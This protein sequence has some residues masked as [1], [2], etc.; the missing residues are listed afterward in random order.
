MKVVVV[1]VLDEDG[2]RSGTH[3]YLGVTEKKAVSLARNEEVKTLMGGMDRQHARAIVRDTMD[4]HV[5]TVDI[6]AVLASGKSREQDGTPAP[7]QVVERVSFRVNRLI[8]HIFKPMMNDKGRCSLCGCSRGHVYH[9]RSPL[10]L[11]T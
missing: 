7:Q 3:A 11:P 1:I 4:F 6:D 2:E 9:R 8:N 5:A 10:G